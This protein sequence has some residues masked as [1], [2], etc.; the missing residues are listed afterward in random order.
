MYLWE[1]QDFLFVDQRSVYEYVYKAYASG[2]RV[3]Q[4]RLIS[5]FSEDASAAAYVTDILSWSYDDS[6]DR[7]KLIFDCIV[8]IRHAIFKRQI[9]EIQEK[10][11]HTPG[12]DPR[13]EGLN[14]DFREL[15]NGFRIFKEMLRIE[16]KKEVEK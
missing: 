11:K 2:Q 13:Q 15:Q 14:A 4:N 6:V 8:K 16:W 9:E 3:S 1:Q 7:M 12:S 10:I 5:V